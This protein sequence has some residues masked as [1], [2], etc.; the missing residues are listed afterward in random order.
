MNEQ[1][2]ALNTDREIWREREGDYYANSIHV[3]QGGGIGI[4]VGGLVIVL[5]L[6]KW[7]KFAAQNLSAA[8]PTDGA[9]DDPAKVRTLPPS[10]PVAGGGEEMEPVAWQYLL[11]N[12]RWSNMPGDWTPDEDALSQHT[13]RPLYAGPPLLSSPRVEECEKLIEAAYRL[14][15]KEGLQKG[16]IA[17]RFCCTVERA[18]AALSPPQGE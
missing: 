9:P 15:V 18:R 12:G 16:P 1:M 8:M 11:P 17:E 10:S 2:A 4:N 3:T 14:G 6:A 13:Y 5:P 7:H